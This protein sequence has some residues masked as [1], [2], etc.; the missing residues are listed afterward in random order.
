MVLDSKSAQGVNPHLRQT[1]SRAVTDSN[2]GESC[3]WSSAAG[4]RHEDVWG[5]ETWPAETGRGPAGEGQ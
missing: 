1:A 2:R 4:S 5:Q 3:W